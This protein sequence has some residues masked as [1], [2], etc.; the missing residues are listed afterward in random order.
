MNTNILKT[1][2]VVCTTVLFVSCDKD[3][4]TIGG[5]II[6]GENFDFTPGEEFGIK[7]YH[8]KTGAVQTN[9]LAINQLGAYNHPVFGEAKS[10]FVTQLTLAKSA[11]TFGEN[12]VVD[13]VVVTIPYFSKATTDTDGKKT[14]ELSNINGSGTI[15]L[16]V[17]RSNYELNDFDPN[18]DLTTNAKYF[19]DQDPTFDSYKSGVTV[20]VN[21]AMGDAR[22]NDKNYDPSKPYYPNENKSFKPSAKEI[23]KYKV[24]STKNTSNPS[25][26]VME[27]NIDKTQ[28]E[29]RLA[30]ALRMRLNEKYFEDNILKTTAANLKD[31]TAFKKYFKGLYFQVQNIASGN[32]S[33]MGLDFKKGNITIYYK[34]DKIVTKVVKDPLNPGSGGV[35]VPEGNDRPMKSLTLNMTGNTVNLFNHTNSSQYENALLLSDP[36]NDFEDDNLYIKGQNGSLGFIE[37][38]TDPMKLQELKDK[39]PLLNEASLTFTVNESIMT[40]T[41]PAIQRLYLYD[42]EAQKVLVDYSYDITTNASD[43]KKNRYI[44]G[45]ILEEIKDDAGNVVK[46]VYKF[47]IT[48]FVNRILKGDQDNVRLG[49]MVTENINDVT[50]NDLKTVINRNKFNDGGTDEV[51]KVQSSSTYNPLGT[52]LYGSNGDNRVKFIINYTTKN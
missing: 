3:Y 24:V 7:V 49:I 11:P 18:N 28:V 45:G 33:T 43:T 13:S 30:P 31:N 19:S 26:Y 51:K 42:A 23:V 44:F 10:N 15:D 21:P 32:G 38:F 41:V 35:V 12:V 8:Q 29:E 34:E 25:Y 6:G 9:N 52:V 16:S 4:N 36:L 17:F 46:K 39:S 47:R 20:N 27:H 40:S 1:L 50:T 14:Y 5:D 37:L 2:A 48:E 22:L